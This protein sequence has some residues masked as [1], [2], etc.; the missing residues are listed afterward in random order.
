MTRYL[1]CSSCNSEQW[2]Q[3]GRAMVNTYVRH[4]SREVPLW[5]Y[6]ENFE[7][8]EVHPAFL[9]L[10]LEDAAPWLAEFKAKYGGDVRWRGGQDGQ[11]YRRNAIKFAHK[12]AA[13]GAAAE[14][15]DCDVLIWLDADIVTFAPVT[16]KWLDS[17]F[18]KPAALA[19]L[20]RSRGIYPECGFVM[21]R[22]PQ[23]RKVIA[24]L[25]EMYRSGA[26]F[27]LPEQHDSFVLQHV[28]KSMPMRVH[29]LSGDGRVH[30][31]HPWCSS[32]LAAT[33]DH[34]KGDT[35]KAQG[36][37]HARDLKVRRDEP[38]WVKVRAGAP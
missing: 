10:R 11:D 21:Y 20:D 4:W 17:L 8:D 33:M 38:Y 1:A 35:R 29:S 24:K 16:T 12:V 23:A 15:A 32:P 22:M 26:V 19:W 3:Y 13:L 7:P 27:G 37:S 18:P 30:T 34:L 31:G 2:Q 6:T 5:F 36:H 9:D 25:V 28:V 14:R